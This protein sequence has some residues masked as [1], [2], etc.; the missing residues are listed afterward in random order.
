M[1]KTILSLLPAALLVFSATTASAGN[2]SYDYFQGSYSL[3]TVDVGGSIGDVDGTSLG[4][5]GSRSITPSV[6][7]VGGVGFGELD[8]VLGV[9]TETTVIDL[10]VAAHAP[11]SP[12]TDIVGS[13]IIVRGEIEQSDGFTTI[14]DSDT[15]N[16]IELRIRHNISNTTELNAYIDRFDIFDDSSISYGVDGL[17]HISDQMS[18]VVGYEVGDDTD[19][20]GAALRINF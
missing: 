10:G 7:V 2:F 20:F 18:I 17:F 13:F 1:N 5:S 19:T 16:V 3:T 14:S 12:E 15:G 9:D 11:I 4:F 8:R 6:A